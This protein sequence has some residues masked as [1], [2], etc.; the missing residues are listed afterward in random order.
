MPQDISVIQL[1]K[2]ERR[3]ETQSDFHVPSKV[4]A[5]TLFNFV[6]RL[7]FL[8]TSLK[9]KMISPRYCEEDLSY[10]HIENM[11]KISYP[12]KCFC[13]INLH[14]L[15][16]HLEWY[17][18]CGLAFSKEW[19]MKKGIQPVQYINPYSHLREDFSEAFS[20]AL[21][22]EADPDNAY[23][24]VMKNVLFHQLMYYKPYSGP[25]RNRTTQIKQEKCFTDECEWRYIPDVT[26][27]GYQQA[28]FEQQILG[29]GGLVNYSNSMEGLKEVSLTFEYKELKY[30]IIH[31]REDFSALVNA[32]E[33]MKLSNSEKLELIS[34]VIIWDEAKGD[35]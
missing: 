16:E 8:I 5:D 19:G 23:L 6:E 35:F 10:L 21:S 28:Y 12:M 13:D 15:S 24:A 26:V 30:V 18:Y 3:E 29:A 22:S 4:Q 31:T 1:S 20:V 27:L 2:A 7:E 25:F 9:N 32:I 14:K 33:D 11:Q 17:G 34:K